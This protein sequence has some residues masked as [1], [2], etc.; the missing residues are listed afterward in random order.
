MKAKEAAKPLFDRQKARIYKDRDLGREKI[1]QEFDEK[2]TP[3]KEELFFKGVSD[4]RR[5]EIEKELEA[6]R[7]DKYKKEQAVDNVATQKYKKIL[8]NMQGVFDPEYEYDKTSDSK[9]ED[10]GIDELRGVI[11]PWFSSMN[12]QRCAVAVEMRERGYDVTTSEG[13]RDSLQ[14]LGVIMSCFRGAKS[15]KLGQNGEPFD[16]D[17]VSVMRSWGDGARALVEFSVEGSGHIFNLVNKGGIVYAVD[18]QSGLVLENKPGGPSWV[19]F[20]KGVL[21]ASVIRVDNL[22]PT[23]TIE[24]YVRPRG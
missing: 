19:G 20:P 13:E 7:H 1:D 2:A 11:N 6:L 8:G 3:L 21:S 15:E 9:P 14:A 16:E 4:E 5:G 17:A 10:L 24:R 22:E 23:V 12:C 18:G